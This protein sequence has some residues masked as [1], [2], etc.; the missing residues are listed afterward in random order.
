M[1]F[2]YPSN[3]NLSGR[4][5]TYVKDVRRSRPSTALRDDGVQVWRSRAIDLVFAHGHQDI[6]SEVFSAAEPSSA[7]FGSVPELLW[8]LNRRATA[9]QSLLYC[10][11]GT[12]PG[13]SSAGAAGLEGPE[14]TRKQLVLTAVV[15][16]T[17]S[18]LSAML[19]YR[20][21][22]RQ[23]KI[24]PSRPAVT[25]VP[26][27]VPC[28]EIAAA[29]P[30]VGQPGCVTGRILRVY[31]SRNGNTFLDFCTDYRKC[32]FTSVVFA[33]DHAKFGDLGALKGRKVELRGLVTEYQGRAEIIIRD[34]EQIRMAP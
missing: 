10:A 23:G 15:V 6:L 7:R 2:G 11:V 32:P 17:V 3:T 9:S 22:L 28:V 16:L 14:L 20:H 27:D 18:I 21:G 30:M 34:Q 13:I 33:E 19:A 4:N 31:T 29:G 25:T 24:A 8:E 26:E 1:H 5:L 12:R